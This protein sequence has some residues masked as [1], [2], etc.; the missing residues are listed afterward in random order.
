M[1]AFARD[2][3][4]R[5]WKEW[6]LAKTVSGAT[7]AAATTCAEIDYDALPMEEDQE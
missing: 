3:L 7:S 2:E 5:L 6:I 4:A 1:Q